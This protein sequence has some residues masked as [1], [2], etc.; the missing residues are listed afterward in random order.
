[1]PCVVDTSRH[2]PVSEIFRT[3]QDKPAP[4]S[5]LSEKSHTNSCETFLGPQRR[6]HSQRPRR[7]PLYVFK[8]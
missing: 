1:M 7:K 2:T 5:Q 8:M 6:I 4:Q 3:A